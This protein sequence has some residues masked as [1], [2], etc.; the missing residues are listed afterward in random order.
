MTRDEL[1]LFESVVSNILEIESIENIQ[2]N[3][4]KEHGFMIKNP[5][6]M[7]A[8]LNVFN[9]YGC[10]VAPE[11]LGKICANSQL[12]SLSSDGFRFEGD[13]TSYQLSKLVELNLSGSTRGLAHFLPAL[14]T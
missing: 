12:T 7:V 9:I 13:M 11:L 10:V 14:E 4:T 5:T 3:I 2:L 6:S 8:N 1:Q